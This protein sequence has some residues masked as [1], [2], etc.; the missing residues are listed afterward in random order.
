[1]AYATSFACLY[2]RDRGS[3]W[4]ERAFLRGAPG[5][6]KGTE[7]CDERSARLATRSVAAFGAPEVSSVRGDGKARLLVVD[8]QAFMRLAIGAVLANDESL[9]VVGEAEDGEEAVE[10]CRALRP[11]LVLMDVEMPMMDGI[12]ATRRIK[13]EFPSTGVLVLTAH[14]DH[15]CLMS[16]VKAGAAGY[17]LKGSNPKGILD[18]VRAVL[19]GE[20]PLDHGLAMRLL[21][22][23]ATDAGP[24]EP[25]ASPS[26]SVTLAAVLPP[27]EV[28][29][30]RLIASG[31]TN[32][33]IAKEL[34]VS[35][36]TVKTHV[37][38]I[39]RK[40]GVSD[41]TQASVKALEMGL[42]LG[43]E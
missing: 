35:L 9:E 22:R 33:Q 26:A 42:L 5:V 8:D 40:L 1:M 36:S 3:C 32:R 27:R 43:Q 41:R 16:A 15:D 37:Q 10:R 21:R 17:V 18:A 6:V 39:I 30:L 11:D 23:L 12:D 20:T 25:P 34:M 7:A 2:S 31:K 14:D 19:G 38:R 13:A 24:R 28:D 4:G 29:T